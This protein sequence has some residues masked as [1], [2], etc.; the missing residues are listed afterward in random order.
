MQ[1]TGKSLFYFE[2]LSIEAEENVFLPVGA[3]K[4]LRRDAFEQVRKQF[5]AQF[6]REDTVTPEDMDN[7]RK[8]TVISEDMD[9]MGKDIVISEDMDNMR[10]DTV[11]SEDIN[12]REKDDQK[13]HAVSKD[14]LKPQIAT[15][16]TTFEQ[17]AAVCANPKVDR[18]Y[19]ETAVMTEKEL[20]QAYHLA[21]EK[22][23]E[24]WLAMPV[25]FRHAIWDRFEHKIQIIR[26]NAYG[27]KDI[28]LIEDIWDGYLIRNMES[29]AFLTKIYSKRKKLRIRLDH[30]M[31]M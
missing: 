13:G 3:I 21:K 22:Q 16:V 14:S 4:Q 29:F 27:Q 1:K 19:F 12:N 18:I 2:K 17:A 10:K 7:M 8:D 23:K 11:I 24:V 26:E 6:W 5:L 30:N 31:C 15:S 20:S 9:N 28:P 25:I